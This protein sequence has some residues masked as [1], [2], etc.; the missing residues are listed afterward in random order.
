VQRRGRPAPA[1]ELTP[2]GAAAYFTAT[3]RVAIRTLQSTHGMVTAMHSPALVLA[4]LLTS[5]MAAAPA[6]H[7]PHSAPADHEIHIVTADLAIEGSVMAG[8]LRFFKHELEQALGPMVG[9]DMV[10]LEP[11]PEADALV[12]R[13]LRDHFRIEAAGEV[14]EA[15]ILQSGEDLLDRHPTWW[16]VVQYQA[17]APIRELTIRNTLLF[18][19]F[20]DQRNVMKL[21]RFPEES[22]E[23]VYFEAGEEERTL[24]L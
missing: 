13:Y 20:D 9:A 16:V 8:R 3:G 5:T 19:M 15:A 1:P 7:G 24:R 6:A 4:F 14:L 21:V 12:L 23:T 22:Q 17:V 2:A 11:G 10:T 18:E